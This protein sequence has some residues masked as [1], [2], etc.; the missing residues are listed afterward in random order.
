MKFYHFTKNRKLKNFTR[1]YVYAWDSE[2]KAREYKGLMGGSGKIIEFE[3]TKFKKYIC[4]YLVELKD[5]IK[6]H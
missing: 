3:A 4:Y 1:E 6:V 5:I 2:W